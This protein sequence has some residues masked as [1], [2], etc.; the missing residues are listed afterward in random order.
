MPAFEVENG[1]PVPVGVQ[2]WRD[3]RYVAHH[4]GADPNGLASLEV[5]E[6]S[7][8]SGAP[9]RPATSLAQARRGDEVAIGSVG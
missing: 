7:V 4:L 3:F 9:E 1:T 5:V 6:F 8:G 2:R